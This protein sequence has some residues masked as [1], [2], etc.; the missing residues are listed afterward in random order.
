MALKGSSEALA[1][2]YT[3]IFLLTQKKTA[4]HNEAM[5]RLVATAASFVALCGLCFA[6]DT[7]TVTN[8]V[9]VVDG[10]LHP[11]QVP[12][13]LAWR[14]YL[15]AV[16]VPQ[17]P[18]ADQ[19]KRQQVQLAE[20]GLAIADQESIARELG[21]MT[22]QLST[23]EAARESG[24]GAPAMLSVLKTQEDALFASTIANVKQAISTDGLS[25]L[26]AYISGTVKKNI[27]IY[28]L[29]NQ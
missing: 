12:D 17:L 6:G 26:S 18:T 15:L 29:P 11:E 9:V 3:V 2:R 7:T 20:V 13:D 5:I 10:S 23:I 19:Q 22:T 21:K 4:H 28:G 16:A 27:R 1:A 14:H 24:D 25:R 8:L